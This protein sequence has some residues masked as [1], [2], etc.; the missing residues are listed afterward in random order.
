[1]NKKNIAIVDRTIRIIII[2]DTNDRPCVKEQIK[3]MIEIMISSSCDQRTF[4][5]N[6]VWDREY[7]VDHT[8]MSKVVFIED[9]LLN[10]SKDLLLEMN[11]LSD[12]E[13][14]I[15]ALMSTEANYFVLKTSQTVFLSKIRDFFYDNDIVDYERMFLLYCSTAIIYESDQKFIQDN[16]D[17]QNLHPW[18]WVDRNS[19]RY[20]L[21]Y[22]DDIDQI[23]L[24]RKENKD[25]GRNASH[26][27]MTCSG[28][29]AQY[30]KEVPNYMS[31]GVFE[32]N[33]Y[34]L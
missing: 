27:Q 34:I 3:R 26:N 5:P 22:L 16:L 10:V 9:A 30:V 19:Y 23:I 1:M 32:T 12:V 11:F 13:K 31:L 14:I 33:H 4:F 21:K 28:D 8:D 6:T 2:D 25:I 17:S 20:C 15:Y 24:S 29:F 7:A 18:V